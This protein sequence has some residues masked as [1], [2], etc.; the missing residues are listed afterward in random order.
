MK[1]T[2]LLIFAVFAFFGIVLYA[3]NLFVIGDHI[4]RMATTVGLPA[5]AAK[6]ISL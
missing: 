3:G 5:A 4:G 1:K 6:W 2:L